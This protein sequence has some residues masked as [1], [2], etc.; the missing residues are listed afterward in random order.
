MIRDLSQTLSNI[1]TKDPNLPAELK[2]AQIVFD[3]PTDTFAPSQTTVDLFLYDIHENL[4][5][6]NNEPSLQRANGQVTITPPPLRVACSYVVTAWPV[7]GTDVALQEHLL[8]G[9]VLQVLSRYT[10]IPSKFLAGSLAGQQPPLPMIVAQA[11]GLR[12]PGDFWTALGSKLRASLSLSVTFSMPQPAP[13]SVP[14]V[15]TEEI[16]LG[17]RT[18]PV[19]TSL[20]PATKEEF[21]RIAGIVTDAQSSPKAN[22]AVLIVEAGLSTNTDAAGSYVL[23]T[24]R[25]GVYT[26]RVTPTG[27]VPQ[28]FQITVPAQSGI[29]TPPNYN[30]KLA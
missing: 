22:S 29:A 16:R 20:V 24:V 8:L 18:S 3:R 19:D 21:F 14:M 23:G 10:T 7:G 28:D 6:R 11:E 30:V 12:S 26:L 25:A 27:G 5:L 15:I 13:P 4:E 9:Q 1:L 17:K 2:G